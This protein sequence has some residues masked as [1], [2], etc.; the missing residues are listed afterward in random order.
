MMLTPNR[1]RLLSSVFEQIIPIAEAYFKLKKGRDANISI[2]SVNSY[3]VS[4]LASWTEGC[5][6]CYDSYDETFHLTHEQ[7]C[8][9]DWKSELDK[10]L[11]AEKQKK[12]LEQRKSA[13]AA[14]RANAARERTQYEQLKKKFES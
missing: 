14:I 10:Q 13:E 1:L 4:F 9:E 6:G 3:D 8:A 7:L 11:E 2:E 5:R 12:I